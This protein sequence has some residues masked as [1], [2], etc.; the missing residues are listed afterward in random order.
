MNEDFCWTHPSRDPYY[1]E[2]MHAEEGRYLRHIKARDSWRFL[3]AAES[4]E[5][6]KFKRLST[7]ADYVLALDPRDR[8]EF[9]GVGMQKLYDFLGGRC[10]KRNFGGNAIAFGW[11]ES[12][13]I[14]S[15]HIL[16]AAAYTVYCWRHSK[17]AIRE[18]VRQPVNE[19]L[20]IPEYPLFQPRTYYPDIETLGEYMKSVEASLKRYEEGFALALEESGVGKPSMPHG[21]KSAQG[22]SPDCRLDWVVHYY[23]NKWG[24][25]SI[26]A[27]EPQQRPGVPNPCHDIYVEERSIEQHIRRFSKSIQLSRFR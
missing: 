12:C 27:E 1:I 21:K 9:I 16:Q 14:R 23:L 26:R 17:E 13:R 22:V 7:Y 4:V 19:V 20:T 2:L 18:V 11:M 15:P 3:K 24:Y 6:T 8:A 5:P 25:R 10:P